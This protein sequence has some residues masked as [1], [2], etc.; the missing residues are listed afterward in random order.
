MIREKKPVGKPMHALQ[1]GDPMKLKTLA[2][3]EFDSSVPLDSRL[4]TNLR[5]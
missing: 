2:R 1:V 4:V 3:L 5:E